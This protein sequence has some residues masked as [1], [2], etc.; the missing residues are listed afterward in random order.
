MVPVLG[1]LG[2]AHQCKKWSRL[3]YYDQKII[4]TYWTEI[5]WFSCFSHNA[6]LLFADALNVIVGRHLTSDSRIEFCLVI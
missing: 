2:I 5:K 1:V 3:C 6:K 4:K